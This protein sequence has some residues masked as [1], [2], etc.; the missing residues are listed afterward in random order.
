MVVYEAVGGAY[1]LHHPDGVLTFPQEGVQGSLYADAGQ[2]QSEYA[3]QVQEKE[4]V[5]KESPDA[6]LG[7]LK[8][9]DPFLMFDSN[10]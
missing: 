9:V 7:V 5:F 6:G 2:Q 8:G 10:G 3:D 1:C 4:K